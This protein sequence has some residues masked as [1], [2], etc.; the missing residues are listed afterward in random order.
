ML[1]AHFSDVIG[2]SHSPDFSF[3]LHNE[4]ASDGLQLLA[5]AGDTQQIETE[6]KEKVLLLS[7]HYTTAFLTKL[8]KKLAGI[9]ASCGHSENQSKPLRSIE[10][11]YHIDARGER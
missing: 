9:A 10:H 5:E 2:A 11:T 7:F 8:F 1:S 3:W 6:L 4:E